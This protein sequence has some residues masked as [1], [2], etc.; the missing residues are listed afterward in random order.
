[1]ATIFMCWWK[2]LANMQLLER[3]HV[4][5]TYDGEKVGNWVR[6]QVNPIVPAQAPG[7]KV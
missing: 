5:E 6:N 4:G 1:M 7:E 2:T 3:R